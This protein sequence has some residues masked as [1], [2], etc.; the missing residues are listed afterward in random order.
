MKRLF[1]ILRILVALGLLAWLLV[2]QNIKELLYQLGNA[3]PIFM[4]LA[5]L[6][7]LFF[8]LISVWRWKVIL[9][10]RD[11]SFTSGYLVKVYFAAC[12]F[13]NIL[14][15]A[16]GGDVIRVI[17]TIKGDNKALAF[18]AT[19]VDRMIGFVGLFFF[20]LSASL[21]LLL[22]KR[23]TSFLVLNVVGFLILILLVSIL[24]SDR[25]QRLF[26]K[27]F[28]PIKLFR[29]GEIFDKLYTAIKD[30][31]K[32]GNALF[33]S[34]ALS[35]LLQADLALT[36]YFASRAVG[37]RL[38]VLYYFLYIPII[39]LLTMIPITIGGLG[40]REKSFVTFFSNLGLKESVAISTSLLFLIV[41]LLYALMGGI[42][43]L[44]LKKSRPTDE[45]RG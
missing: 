37:A 28:R 27:V 34:F 12:F 18:S 8:V 33:I 11:Q 38:S 15:T 7:F 6:A 5:V 30:Y 26:S 24:F 43:F 14:P 44:F 23:Q 3:N 2:G 21:A 16:I 36:W 20:A 10:A 19:F 9:D 39:G 41:N 35:L 40:V 17:Y 13:N 1:S 25:A 29:L 42:V 45:V 4:L 32:F 22:L 31:R